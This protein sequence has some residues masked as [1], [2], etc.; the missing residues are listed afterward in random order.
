MLLESFLKT[1]KGHNIVVQYLLKFSCFGDTVVRILIF[2]ELLLFNIFAQSR[3]LNL[4]SCTYIFPYFFIVTA[5]Q[6][7]TVHFKMFHLHLVAK[8]FCSKIKQN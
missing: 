8:I 4:Q 3:K 2:N 7:V 6:I 5:L 1:E